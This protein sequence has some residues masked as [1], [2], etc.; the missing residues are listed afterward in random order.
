MTEHTYSLATRLRAIA[1][2]SLHSFQPRPRPSPPRPT[3]S[4]PAADSPHTPGALLRAQSL[5]ADAPGVCGE[6]C[7]HEDVG[8]VLGGE[9]AAAG[10]EAMQT[11]AGDR[12]Q[13]RCEAVGVLGHDLSLFG[14]VMGAP[15]SAGCAV[16]RRGGGVNPE[17]TGGT[18]GSGFATPRAE[19]SW[20]GPQMPLEAHGRSRAEPPARRRGERASPPGVG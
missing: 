10:L 13:P 7:G 16:N 4:S 15:V 9:G 12:A 3:I 2:D 11:V 19:A 14:L 1:C 5:G 20:V 6:S 17:E 18:A 8:Q